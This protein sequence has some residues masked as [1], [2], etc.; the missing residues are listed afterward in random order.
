M[1]KRSTRHTV[2]ILLAY[3]NRYLF[4]VVIVLITLFFDAIYGEK[5]AAL[6]MGICCIL[7][8][9]YELIGYIRRW[10]HIYC[11]Y[12]NVYRQ[13]M[14]PH[15]IRWN[16]IEKKDAYGIPAIFGIFGI[17]AIVVFFFV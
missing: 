10:K 3:A 15:D 5:Y 6:V 12:Q 2:I 4:P 17:V 11:S 8:A 7:F 9:L 13:E 14:T 16:K 1:S